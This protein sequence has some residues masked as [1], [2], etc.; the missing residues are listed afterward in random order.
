MQCWKTDYY[1]E[2]PTQMI[3]GC[4]SYELDI[5]C[6]NADGCDDGACAPSPVIVPPQLLRA[7]GDAGA[8][9]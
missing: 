2:D 3:R 9:K 6:V 7:V 5:Y 1:S 4:Y 8:F